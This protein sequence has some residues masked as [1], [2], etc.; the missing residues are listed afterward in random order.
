VGFRESLFSLYPNNL[1]LLFCLLLLSIPYSV[2]AQA[3]T[4]SIILAASERLG[5]DSTLPLSIAYA[6]SRYKNVP[7]YAYDGEK[8]TSTAYGPFQLTRTFYK[9]FC[10]DPAERLIVEKNIECALKVMKT[11]KNPYLHWI[12]SY[13]MNGRGWRYLPHLNSM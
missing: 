13:E 9:S 6:E 2:N 11:V 7:N 1:K 4:R 10:G 12:E 5:V 3:D 8:G